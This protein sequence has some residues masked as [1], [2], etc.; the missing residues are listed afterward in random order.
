M[1]GG[2]MK[3]L[4]FIVL[5]MAAILSA[6]CIIDSAD[7]QT[8]YFSPK[9][10]QPMRA[11]VKHDFRDNQIIRYPVNLNPMLIRYRHLKLREGYTIEGNVGHTGWGGSIIYPF[12]VKN[13]LVENNP[14]SQFELPAGSDENIMAYISGDD[15]LQSYLEASIFSRDVYAIGA[16][17]SGLI[18][19]PQQVVIDNPEKPKVILNSTHAIVVFSTEELYCGKYTITQYTDVFVRKDYQYNSIKKII[20][21]EK[22]LAGVC[23]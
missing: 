4:L 21:R 12:I 14:N 8:L 10:I 7:N 2:N 3:Y 19:W 5:L 23:Y 20:R 1:K 22:N 6:G 16:H 9:E 15:T 13:S 18:G 11:A 17:G